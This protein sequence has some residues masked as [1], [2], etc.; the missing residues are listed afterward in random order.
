MV[1]KEDIPV[2]S[3]PKRSQRLITIEP[4]ERL[5]ESEGQRQL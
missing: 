5:L 2:P 3:A 4:A 1:P